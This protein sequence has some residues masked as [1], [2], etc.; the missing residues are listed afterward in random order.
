MW[1]KII[2]PIYRL[3]LNGLYG[4]YGPRCPL[5]SKR[6]INLI[7]LSL[8]G[9]KCHGVNLTGQWVC[10]ATTISITVT[11]HGHHGTT[12]H[13]RLD[14]LYNSLLGKQKNGSSY[15]C[16]FV[17]GVCRWPM[18]SGHKDREIQKACPCYDIIFRADSRFA[19]SQ[20]ETA[21]LCND[22]SHW[23]GAKLESALIL[24]KWCSDHHMI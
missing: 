23:L 14:C 10:F 5:S 6:P 20:W 17:R 21:L 8:S 2:I 4:L 7:S 3:W 19:P 12:N 9:S 18:D 24:T 15:Y 1:G 11:L 16:P 22:V 13:W